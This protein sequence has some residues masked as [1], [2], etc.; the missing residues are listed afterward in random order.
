MPEKKKQDTVPEKLPKDK[1]VV[2]HRY[3]G[4]D[5]ADT[6]KLVHDGQM[7]HIEQRKKTVKTE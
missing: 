3:L 5:I 6:D 4:D 1:T 2:N 7:Y